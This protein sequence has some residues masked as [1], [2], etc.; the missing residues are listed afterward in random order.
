MQLSRSGPADADPA[1]ATA[2]LV[3]LLQA[4]LVVGAMAGGL[5]AGAL[6]ARPVRQVLSRSFSLSR[7]AGRGL[8]RVFFF[9]VCVRKPSP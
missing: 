8:V 3:L 4:A 6:L 7:Y 9:T 1:D 5:F 2:T